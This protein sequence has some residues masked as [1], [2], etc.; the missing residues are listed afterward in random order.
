MK[1]HELNA[2]TLDERVTLIQQ[3]GRLMAQRQSQD[4]QIILY[5][6]G[7]YFLEIHYR[8]HAFYGVPAAWAPFLVISF[9]NGSRCVDRLLPYVDSVNLT[10]LDGL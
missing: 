3:K 2:A 4:R 7:H 8:L 5:Q 10:A 9:R 6:W 1:L